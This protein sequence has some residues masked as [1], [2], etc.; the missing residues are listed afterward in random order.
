MAAPVPDQYTSVRMTV[1]ARDDD[2][3]KKIFEGMQYIAGYE[4]LPDNKHYHIM[5]A[6]HLTDAVKQ[7]KSRYAKAKAGA[8]TWSKPDWGTWPQGVA[9]TIK[10]GNWFASSEPYSIYARGQRP[11]ERPE[12]NNDEAPANPQDRKKRDWM[13]H[14]CNI[15]RLYQKHK[16]NVPER[17]GVHDFFDV[18]QWIVRNTNWTITQSFERAIGT[19]M[20]YMCETGDKGDQRTI[21]RLRRQVEGGRRADSRYDH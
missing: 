3:V 8:K 16:H 1:E 10:D 12:S 13:L 21:D 18:L 17:N 11:Y 6:G 7:R 2:V 5:V 20:V 14:E 15:R 19:H 9:Y 4:E